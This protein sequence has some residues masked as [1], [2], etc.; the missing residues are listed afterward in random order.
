[1]GL[2]KRIL[3]YVV[4]T[5]NGMALGLFATLI[6]GVII[7][8]FAS[9]LGIDALQQLA[10]ALKGLMGA[11]IGLGVAYSLGLKGLPLI[12]GAMAGGIATAIIGANDPLVAYLT[13][14]FAIEGTRLVLR[15]P[16]PLDIL[17][18]P[19]L[20]ALIALGVV[21]LIGPY[22]ASA[23]EALRD[24]IL[25]ATER[26]P[27]TMGV[28]IAVV[29]GM[30]LTMPISSAAIAII[31]GL[32]GIAAGAALVGGAAQMIG[33]AVMSRKDLR[34]GEV[35]SIAFGTSMLQFKNVI[36]NPRVWIP[37]IATSAIL[38][39]L[40][41]LV[42]IMETTPEGAGMGTS[43]LVGPLQTLDAMGYD[44]SV[45]LRIGLLHFVLPVALVLGLDIWLRK[46]GWIKPGDLSLKTE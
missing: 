18:V 45:F 46:M 2:R 22:V 24:F 3:N 14:V 29:M 36:R 26:Q 17:L 7:E 20:T 35:L 30:A 42:F 39:P 31:L 32:S 15:K 40:A 43:A 9:L 41:T 8:Q 6:V 21:L 10:E 23:M 4:K 19:I 28:L 27:F 11:G 44:I 1:M 38:G 5:L 34:I 13:T 16:T 25:W 12:A 33:F 37:P